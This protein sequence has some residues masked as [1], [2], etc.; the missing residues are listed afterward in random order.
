MG[1]RGPFLFHTVILQLAILLAMATATPATPLVIVAPPDQRPAHALYEDGSFRWGD[2][3]GC[4][5][6]AP[7]ND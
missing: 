3:T 1:R 2:L 6:A 7:C 5:P 4:L